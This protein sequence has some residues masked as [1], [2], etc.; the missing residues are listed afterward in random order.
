MIGMTIFMIVLFSF[1]GGVLIQGKGSFLIAGYN[2]M[3]E[4]EKAEMDEIALCRFLGKMMFALVFAFII[5]LI[6]SIIQNEVISIAG[7]ALTVPLVIF[8]IIYMNT[9]SR[10]KKK[11][12]A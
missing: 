6:G 11:E 4:E 3:T 7:Y 12:Q 9:G 5:S 8:M 1:F 10:F 2:T